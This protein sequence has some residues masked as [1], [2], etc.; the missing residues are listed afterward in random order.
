MHNLHYFDLCA[1]DVGYKGT[2]YII[3]QD[4]EN[5]STP[6]HGNV[7][8]IFTFIAMIYHPC[9]YK[10]ITDNALSLAVKCLDL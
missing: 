10:E 5:K 2:C 6:C 3:N 1:F 7:C 8:H 4:N 9:W